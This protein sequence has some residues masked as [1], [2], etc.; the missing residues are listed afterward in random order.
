MP[1]HPFLPSAFLPEEISAPR[2]AEKPSVRRSDSARETPLLPVRNEASATDLSSVPT[3]SRH[4]SPLP[5]SRPNASPT[6]EETAAVRTGRKKLPPDMR[7]SKHP[8]L[9]SVPPTDG[10]RCKCS[11]VR[12]TRSPVPCDRRVFRTA[13][14]SPSGP[15]PESNRGFRIF[16]PPSAAPRRY[17]AVRRTES[18]DFH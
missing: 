3:S 1:G 14:P 15:A 6:D 7:D 17:C 12:D 18:G 16:S 9:R 10:A 8:F 4:H 11:S 13:R 5:G 2:R